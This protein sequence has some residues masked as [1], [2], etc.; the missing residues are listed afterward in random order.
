M[1]NHEVKIGFRVDA[2][3]IIGTGHLIEIMSL[4]KSLRKRVD[5]YAVAIVNEYTMCKAKLESL[6]EEIEIMPD[7]IAEEEETEMFLSFLKRQG[8]AIFVTDLLERSVKYYA[9]LNKRVTKTYILLDN[10][11]HVEIPATAVVNFNIL[12]SP[13]YYEITKQYETQYLIGPK[14]ALLDEELHNKWASRISFREKV[15]KIFLNQGGS[16]PYGLT[17]KIL[18]VLEKL[19]LRQEVIVVLGGA[20]TPRHRKEIDS[21]RPKLKD[22]YRFYENISQSMMYELLSESDMALTA[23]G[24]TLYELAFFGIP[25]IIIGHHEQHNKVAEKFQAEGA[26]INLGIGTRIDQEYI[27]SAVG[28]LIE[29][30][31]K[32][33]E[34]SLRSRSIVDG[35]GT[36][37]VA[38]KI[39][40][41]I[42]T[43]FS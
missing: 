30:P 23:A 9:T 6:V 3:N 11:K 31:E 10:D 18:R 14:Y 20:I 15:D 12:Q 41:D 40:Q 42:Q 29:N 7:E 24:N 26:A 32:R 1:G 13:K 8:I 38:N 36:G 19:S 17:A 33:K 39:V 21:L 27:A 34:L 28:S 22:N 25:S 2:S 35:Y 43:L 16:D 5:F 4:I 37:R